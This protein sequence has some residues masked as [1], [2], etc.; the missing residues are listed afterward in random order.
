MGNAMI[1]PKCSAVVS[2]IGG[3][4]GLVCSYC[5]VA[6]CWATKQLRWGPNVSSI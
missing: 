2:K 4:D 1:C 5:K 6:L 3:C